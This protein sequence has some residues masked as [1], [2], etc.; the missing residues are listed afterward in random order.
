MRS[1]STLKD[2][3]L[4]EVKDIAIYFSKYFQLVS[5]ERIFYL[6][7]QVNSIDVALHLLNVHKMGGLTLDFIEYSYL[8]YEDNN[9]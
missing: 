3:T 5:A 4:N 1:K 6:I 9:E 8:Q 7:L 2:L